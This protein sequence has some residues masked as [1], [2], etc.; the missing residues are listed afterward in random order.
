MHSLFAFARCVQSK[1]VH[2]PIWFFNLLL[3]NFGITQLM[4]YE[5]IIS[6][7]DHNGSNHAAGGSNNGGQFLPPP[8]LSRRHLRT[9]KSKPSPLDDTTNVAIPQHTDGT[10]LTIEER[11]R[12]LEL[13][14]NAHFNF[15][16]HPFFGSMQ[17][18]KCDDTSDLRSLGCVPGSDGYGKRKIVLV[19]MIIKF[20]LITC[21]NQIL[22][23]KQMIKKKR[24]RGKH[25][26]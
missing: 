15:G 3:V 2:L 21:Q 13:K 7:R 19:C 9:K 10:Q 16:T 14:T 12:Y 8:F 22:I 18:S 23:L 25:H 4:V 6:D 24:T 20:V 1:R 17:L 26:V 11:L 5:A